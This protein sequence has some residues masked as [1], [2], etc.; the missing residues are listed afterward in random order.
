MYFFLLEANIEKNG[1]RV[2][3]RREQKMSF[4]SISIS[5]FGDDLPTTSSCCL[6]MKAIFRCICF[7]PG[8]LSSSVNMKFD[9]WSDS[10]VWR[11]IHFLIEWYVYTFLRQIKLFCFKT[12]IYSVLKSEYSVLKTRIFWYRLWQRYNLYSLPTVLNL[13]A[14]NDILGI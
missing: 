3:Q 7:G 1:L 6:V 8:C 10:H 4:C 2:I 14:K 12:W 13:V 9:D 11:M 5:S